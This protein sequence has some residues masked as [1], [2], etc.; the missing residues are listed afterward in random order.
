MQLYPTS[1]YK[2]LPR[3]LKKLKKKMKR[4]GFIN[5]VMEVVTTDLENSLNHMIRNIEELRY[6]A[7]KTNF[8]EMVT[9]DGLIRKFE[10]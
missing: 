5:F 8:G 10:R 4:K 6:K 1:K 7:A 9:F 3:K 2:R